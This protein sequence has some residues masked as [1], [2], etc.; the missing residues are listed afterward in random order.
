MSPARRQSIRQQKQMN[1]DSN[2]NTKKGVF[3]LFGHR[4]PNKTRCWRYHAAAS[5]KKNGQ[6]ENQTG[7]KVSGSV[8]KYLHSWLCVVRADRVRRLEEWR[9]LK[10]RQ[11]EVMEVREEVEVVKKRRRKQRGDGATAA[12]IQ[13]FSNAS[14]D[15]LTGAQENWWLWWDCEISQM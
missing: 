6:N 3:L 2:I 10:E 15:P 7:T 5:H 4:E 9:D 12:T 14:P 11:E 8:E 1:E 13:H